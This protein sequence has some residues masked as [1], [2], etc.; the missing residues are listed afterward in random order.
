MT[1]RPLPA[2]GPHCFLVR[3]P[4]WPPSP[5]S[6]LGCVSVSGSPFGVRIVPDVLCHC[7]TSSAVRAAA[8][9]GKLTDSDVFVQTVEPADTAFTEATG[10]SFPG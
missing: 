4:L 2:F 1:F 8:S 3:F 7:A 6:P 5:A 10:G 9:P